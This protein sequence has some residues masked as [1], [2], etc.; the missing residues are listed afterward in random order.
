M[1]S[2][3]VRTTFI[4]ASLA[5]L[6][7]VLVAQVQVRA[8]AVISAPIVAELPLSGS[9]VSPRSSNLTTQ[10]SGLVLSIN[11]DAGDVVQ[12]GDVL[13]ELDGQLTKLE[14]DRLLAR[15]EEAVLAF[16]DAKRLADEG[17]RLI[18]DRNIS[19]SQFESRLA[20]EAGE[21][22]RL[23]QLDSQVQ[24]QQVKLARHVLKAPFAGVIG[25]KHT[26]IGQW[27]NAGNTAFQLVQL[28]PLRVQ[29]NVP[30]RYFEEIRP[31]VKVSVS[32]DAHPGKVIHAEVQ[33]IVP[34]TDFKTRSFTA[35]MDVPNPE[36][37]LAPG[38]SAH[39]VFELGGL[40]SRAVLQ[41]PADAIVRRNDGSAAVWVVRDGVANAV[42][43][44]VGRRNQ[45]SVEVSAVDLREGD[46]VVTLGN[47]SL[48]P[49]I[50]V[51]VAQE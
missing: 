34:V 5:C 8:E 21:E 22:T 16:Q 27:L 33:S 23:R 36:R 19:K 32:V 20:T 6:P 9:V 48:R 13:L 14:L 49:D 38:M 17:R 51:T 31:G 28:D 29:A 4:L 12:E 26:E 11:V 45:Q 50:P 43:V 3:I 44:T 35:R 40:E 15:Q 24:S 30:E 1:N 47:E 41:V 10:E 39:L 7:G 46:L 25:F 37:E 42:P 18:N 2:R